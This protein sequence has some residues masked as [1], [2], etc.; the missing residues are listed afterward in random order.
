MFTEVNR[1][2]DKDYEP[3]KYKTPSFLGELKRTKKMASRKKHNKQQCRKK[4]QTVRTT[5]QRLKTES[6]E[7]YINATFNCYIKNERH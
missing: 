4:L 7:F 3:S 2:E 6:D 5:E 1:R